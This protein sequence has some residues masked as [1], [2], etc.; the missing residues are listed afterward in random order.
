MVSALQSPQTTTQKT[1]DPLV[2]TIVAI[3]IVFVILQFI[4]VAFKNM[5]QNLFNIHFFAMTIAGTKQQFGCG[6]NTHHLD[7]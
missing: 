7:S 1:F 4:A 2:P 6:L 3:I 5:Q